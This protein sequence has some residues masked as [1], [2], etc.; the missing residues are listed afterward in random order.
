[1]VVGA[2][3]GLDSR[4]PVVSQ[5]PTSDLSIFDL[6]SY[7]VGSDI[8]SDPSPLRAATRL[9][10]LLRA[11]DLAVGLQLSNLQDHPLSSPAHVVLGPS[12][13]ANDQLRD[14]ALHM[15]NPRPIQPR[16]HQVP[17]SHHRRLSFQGHLLRA[18]L[19]RKQHLDFR[20]PLS[21]V[22][23][24]FT[25]VF[26]SSSTLTPTGRASNAPSPLDPPPF[27]TFH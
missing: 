23:M 19:L 21:S 14:A 9:S 3:P 7:L 18:L 26:A 8:F 12:P 27:G 15:M 22:M 5:S 6:L 10:A 17:L 16:L 20:T 4:P 1:M 24:T 13:H 11:K 25:Y 2:P